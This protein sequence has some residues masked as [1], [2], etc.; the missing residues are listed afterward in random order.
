MILITGATG[1]IG[2]H[3]LQ[4]LMQNNT[5]LRVLLTEQQARRL[6]WDAEHPQAPEI[7]VGDILDEEAVYR[8]TTGV[9]TI[10][11]LEGALWWGRLRDLERIE[12]AG[13]RNLVTQARAA[14]VG[15][16]IAMSQLGAATS[17]A[18]ELHR[19]KGQVEQ[20]IRNSGIAYTIIRAGV[21]YGM[22][23]SFI[24]HIAM[25]MRI[26]PVFFLMPGQGEVVLHPI[27]I[28]DLT[29]A[30][31]RALENFKVIDRVVEIGGQEYTTLEDM[32]L[33]IM[34]VRGMSRIIIAAPPY[35]LRFFTAIYSR[36]FPRSLM[37]SHWLDIL[38]TNRTT[39]LSNMYDY[40]GFQPRRFEDT[41]MEY[42]PRQRLLWGALK[43]TFRRRP[44]SI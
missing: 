29:E 21:V 22:Q 13:T 30:L 14:R 2:R 11:H 33:T 18:Y 15:R 16:I 41:L 35:L 23:D 36:L 19:A 4:R 31:M 8:A 26:N 1:F 39:Q 5:P 7:V 43:R 42:L 3:V 12:I 28:D 17:S 27:Y 6:P 37:T 10:L 40:F 20:I 9:H 25:M 24:N 34:R 32:L 38:A 44:R